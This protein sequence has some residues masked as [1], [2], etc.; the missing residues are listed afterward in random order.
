MVVELSSPSMLLRDYLPI[1]VRDARHKRVRTI[2]HGEEIPLPV[3][4]YSVSVVLEDGVRYV[5]TTEIKKGKVAKVAF[6]VSPEARTWSAPEF[7]AVVSQEIAFPDMKRV[8][9]TQ[10][11]MPRFDG[12]IAGTR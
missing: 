10:A 1:E 6:D 5:R 11:G 2:R 12:G 3:G 7:G 4:I 9:S 8:W